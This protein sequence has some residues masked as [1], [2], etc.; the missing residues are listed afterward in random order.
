MF[1]H[2]EQFVHG[3]RAEGVAY[4]RPVESHP[5]GAHVGPVEGERPM[6]GEVHQ[7]GEAVDGSPAAFVE[8]FRDH[9]RMPSMRARRV[10]SSRSM[11]SCA[12]RFSV[13]CS[14][15]LAPVITLDTCGLAAHQAM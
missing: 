7:V 1:E 3:L 14:G 12:A 13:T 2:G 8:R 10:S 6:V 5:Y 11:T 15:R 9:F 4:L